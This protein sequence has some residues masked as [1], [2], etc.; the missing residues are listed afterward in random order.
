[1]RLPSRYGLRAGRGAVLVP[2]PNVRSVE[3]VRLWRRPLSWVRTRGEQ[4]P[5]TDHLWPARR[6]LTAR[7]EGVPNLRHAGRLPDRGSQT[8][9]RVPDG[10]QRSVELLLRVVHAIGLRCG[11]SRPDHKLQRRRL[12]YL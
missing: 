10:H 12:F 3:L 11:V 5:R 1:M 9:D 7:H 2:V 8:R 6:D 4:L